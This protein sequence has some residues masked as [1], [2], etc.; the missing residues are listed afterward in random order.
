MLLKV[1]FI[2]SCI[3]NHKKYTKIRTLGSHIEMP[4]ENDKNVY[5]LTKMYEGSLFDLHMDGFDSRHNNNNKEPS[6]E[7]LSHNLLRQQLLQKLECHEVSIHD[8]ITII[9][10][11]NFIFDKHHYDTNIFEGGL[12]DDWGFEL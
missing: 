1:L 8:K 12:T 7:E 5:M 6:V 4:T 2:I 11:F 9:N 10:D 3:F